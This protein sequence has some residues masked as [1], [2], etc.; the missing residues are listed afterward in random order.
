MGMFGKVKLMLNLKNVKF[1]NKKIETSVKAAYL[2]GL[3]AGLNSK[4]NIKLKKD[5]LDEL[6]P[7]AETGA[8]IVFGDG[9]Y[10]P[11]SIAKMV[12]YFDSLPLSEKITLTTQKEKHETV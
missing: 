7:H 9:V 5:I 10:N 11:I 1:M 3:Y 12:L 8:Q 2:V 4:A 6:K